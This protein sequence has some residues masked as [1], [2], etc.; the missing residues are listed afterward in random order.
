VPRSSGRG[1]HAAAAGFDAR[2]KA[3]F[4]HA[5]VVDWISVPLGVAT[6]R[7]QFIDVE[8]DGA[9][10]ALMSWFFEENLAGFR[11]LCRRA[12]ARGLPDHRHLGHGDDGGGQP[13]GAQAL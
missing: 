6:L 11:A 7:D 13:S 1:D 4:P 8:D 9:R 3:R 12:G 5:K 10:F 2:P